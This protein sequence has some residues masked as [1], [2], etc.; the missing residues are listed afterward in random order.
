MDCDEKRACRTCGKQRSSSEFSP[1]E[2]IKALKKNTR[3]GK[4]KICA[5]R[6]QEHR[7][8]SKCKERKEDN[9]FTKRM[10]RESDETRRCIACQRSR[11]NPGTWTC[12]ACKN[13]FAKPMFSMWLSKRKDKTRIDGKA[14]CNNC[15][16]KQSQAELDIA[17][18]AAE[19]V[20]AKK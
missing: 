18:N 9:Q 14:W 10:L 16:R 4:C 20:Q 19:H 12:L 2:W 7:V 3:R 17:R 5:E 6:N 8:Y 11:S 13:S 1:S 15:K